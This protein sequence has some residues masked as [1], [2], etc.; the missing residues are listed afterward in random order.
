MNKQ[1]ECSDSVTNDIK[2]QRTSPKAKC[3]HYCILFARHQF[4]TKYILIIII[5]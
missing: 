5:F 3:F 4:M 2:K 1:S